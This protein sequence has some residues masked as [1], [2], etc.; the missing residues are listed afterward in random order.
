V[1]AATLLVVASF[2]STFVGGL[3]SVLW[4]D[5]F[6]FVIFLGSAVAVLVFLRLSIPATN[7]EIFQGL[8]HAPGNIDKLRL[9]DFSADPSKPFS[10]L[11]IVTGIAL[12][13]VASSGLDQDTTQR[14]LACRDAKTGARSLYWSVFATVP[15]VAIFITIGLLLHIFYDRAELM[16]GATAVAG[17]AFDGEKISIFMHYILTQLPSGLRGLVTAGI[18]AAAVATTNSALNAMSSVLIQDF[19]RPWRERRSAPA[20]YHY[21]QAGRAGMGVIG[22]A[23]LGVA[24]LSFYWQHYAKLGLLEFALQV[25]VF[26]YAGLLG[27]YFAA[28]LTPRGNSMSVIASLIAGFVTVL[29]LQPAIATAIGLPPALCHLA[30]PF[31]LCIGTAIAF[32]IAIAPRGRRDADGRAG[33]AP[34]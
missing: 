32:A 25:M 23:M 5:L 3:R 17:Q 18:V 7:V 19:Y 16:G 26:A 27:V 2:L 11:A 6:Q 13:Y 14:L 24:V 15:V 33:A 10:L 30:F 29:L 1:I 22:V 28:V 34:S 9:F 31:Q 20:E 21:V 8:A 4:I 12:L